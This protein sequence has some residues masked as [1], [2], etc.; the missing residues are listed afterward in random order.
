[1][2]LYYRRCSRWTKMSFLWKWAVQW[3][4]QQ[5]GMVVDSIL[6]RY[7]FYRHNVLSHSG[8]SV[9]GFRFYRFFRFYRITRELRKS[10]SK[11]LPPLGSE[12]R[13]S[14]FTAL[15]A[16]IW[17]ISPI[18]WKSLP[19]GYIKDLKGW[20]FQQIGELSQAVACKT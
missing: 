19:F 14:D 18:C 10:S 9:I 12:P 1:M 17:A 8:F 5:P 20:D 15:H 7:R 16:T 6:F 2:L 4:M 3:R 11:M 13:A